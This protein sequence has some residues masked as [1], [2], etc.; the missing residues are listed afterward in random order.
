MLEAPVGATGEA[1]VSVARS[2]E[3]LEEFRPA[4]EALRGDSI[5]SDL[6]YFTEIVRSEPGVI[7][8]HSVLVTDGDHPRGLA[9]ARLE[10]VPLAC[11]VGYRT[12]YAP[13]MRVLAVAYEGLLGGDDAA[14]AERLF[15]E[16]WEALRRDEADVLVFRRLRLDSPAFRL[17]HRHPPAL[18]R[19]RWTR[20]QPSF[21][22]R[23]PESYPA[24]Y[25]S[26]SKN[27]RRAFTKH[28]N[29]IRRE[30]G[31]RVTAREFRDPADLD[32]FFA[33]AEA[34]AHKTYQRRIGVGFRNDDAT[35][36]R[37]HLS[38]SRGWFWGWIL[39]L[40]DRPV[41]FEQGEIYRGR[42]QLAAT[43]FDPELRWYGVG[44]FLMLRW[45]Q[46]A[47]RR[48]EISIVDF[49]FGDADYKRRLCNQTWYEADVVVAAPRLRPVAINLL[50][51]GLEASGQSADALVARLGVRNRLKAG[52]RRRLSRSRETTASA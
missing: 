16:L 33:D 30:F 20:A 35:R 29:R 9:L 1:R 34:V 25:R 28:E 48:P 44:T 52:W 23:L 27:T 24:L 15:D 45:L 19:A 5:S 37:A 39:Y 7:R 21:A 40:D 3:E 10:R 14:I 36:R 8:P 2:L 22:I 26:L 4:W 18:S 46:D 49:G 11:R 32:R 17:A 41:A 6:D 51:T 43:G 42:L 12:I 50:R 31:D 38:A 47:F 13:R